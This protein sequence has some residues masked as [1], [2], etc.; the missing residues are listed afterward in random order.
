MILI[1]TLKGNR[2]ELFAFDRENS[3]FI[4]ISSRLGPAM[5]RTA[6]LGGS[7]RDFTKIAQDHV[8]GIC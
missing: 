1:L 7:W 8:K 3:K 2:P 5:S 4:R 6:G